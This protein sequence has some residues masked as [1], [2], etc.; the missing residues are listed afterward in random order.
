MQNKVNLTLDIKE[1]KK[2]LKKVI[3]AA[4]KFSKELEILEKTKFSTNIKEVK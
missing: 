2:Q 1:L 3:I 4:N